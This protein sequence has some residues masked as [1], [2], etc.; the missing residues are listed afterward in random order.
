MHNRGWS[1]RTC[2]RV[3]DAVHRHAEVVLGETAMILRRNIK[4]FAEKFAGMRVH[5][6]RVYP[7]LQLRDWVICGIL[8]FYAICVSEN[9]KPQG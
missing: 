9:Y 4:N 5:G 3:D 1:A 2:R 7:Q 6:T 8:I